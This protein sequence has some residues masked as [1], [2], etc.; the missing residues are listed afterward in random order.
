[1]NDTLFEKLL[2]KPQKVSKDLTGEGNKLYLKDCKY[3]SR[4]PKAPKAGLGPA[5]SSYGIP[6]YLRFQAYCALALEKIYGEECM[7]I[8][9]RIRIKAGTKW[10]FLHSDQRLLPEDDEY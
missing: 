8:P 7:V 4:F 10:G 6:E 9:E 5:A 2:L 1:M 3:C